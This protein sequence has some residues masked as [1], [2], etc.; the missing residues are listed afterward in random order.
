MLHMLFTIEL[1]PASEYFLLVM[2]LV[3]ACVVGVCGVGAPA[4]VLVWRSEGNLQEGGHSLLPPRVI[5]DRTQ[6]FYESSGRTRASY[7]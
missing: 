4:V 6:V 7:F 1:V 2:C 5:Q 3:C